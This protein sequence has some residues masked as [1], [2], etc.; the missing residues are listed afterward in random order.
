MK[1]RFSHILR[2]YEK[3]VTLK[4]DTSSLSNGR[5]QQTNNEYIVKLTLIPLTPDRI[6][7]Y[8]GGNYTTQDKKGLTREGLIGEKIVEGGDNVEE[9]VELK[10]NDI[11]VEDDGTKYEIRE[12]TPWTD[13]A[14]FTT[15]VAKKVV[16]E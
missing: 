4:K 14:D 6:N 11:I 15:F 8:E 3:E 2:K 10:N 5:L 13:F 1:L 7:E 12:D 9:E 16:V